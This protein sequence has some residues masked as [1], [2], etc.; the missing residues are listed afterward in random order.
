MN[1]PYRSPRESVRKDRW[2]ALAV[3]VLGLLGVAPA[4]ALR[5]VQVYEVTVRGATAAT[6]VADGMRQAL[7]RATGRRDAP[8]N[9]ALAAIVQNAALY[10]KGTR[11]LA[12]GAVQLDFDGTA[13]AQAIVAA[14]GSLWDS[15]RPFTLVAI[16]PVPSGPAGDALRVLLE[17]TAEERGLP[18]SLVPLTTTDGSGA[19]LADDVV[20]QSAKTLGGDAVLIGRGDATNPG[21]WQWHLV[22]S[23]TSAGWTGASEVGINGAADSLASVAADTGAKPLVQVAVE[24]A[25]VGTLND[26]ARVEQLLRTTPGVQSSGLAAA[27]GT[28]AIFTVGVRGGGEAL[29][30]ALAGSAHL[31]SAAAGETQVQLNYTP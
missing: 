3:T 22:S 18:I 23:Y 1:P 13:L 25:G 26:Y 14:G 29:A 19:P 2:I 21:Q 15:N 12:G 27:Q 6:V 9:P 17:Q 11:S 4:W 8:A 28:T 24:V 5:P 30:R 16:N 31:S 20:L 7:V 10:L